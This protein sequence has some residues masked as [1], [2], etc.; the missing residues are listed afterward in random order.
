M[1]RPYFLIFCRL[2]CRKVLGDLPGLR[3]K[4]WDSLK[5]GFGGLRVGVS[6]VQ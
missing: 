2:H 6:E 4:F 5:A 1:H 3:I